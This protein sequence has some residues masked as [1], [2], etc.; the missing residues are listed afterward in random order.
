MASLQGLPR[1]PLLRRYDH[2]QCL[3][4]KNQCPMYI[5]HHLNGTKFSIYRPNS[6]IR[7]DLA[8]LLRVL[9]QNRH[10][11]L[12][13]LPSFTWVLMMIGI[14]SDQGQ[15]MS[16]S[17]PLTIPPLESTTTNRLQD[18]PLDPKIST[19]SLGESTLSTVLRKCWTTYRNYAPYG[20]CTYEEYEYE[21]TIELE[22]HVYEA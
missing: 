20:L 19:T 2:N 21:M 3:C 16:T 9:R 14:L 5:I 15:L 13:Y 1:S 8:R 10:A 11:C 4:R 7:L 17:S 18:R 22:L 6:A 12:L